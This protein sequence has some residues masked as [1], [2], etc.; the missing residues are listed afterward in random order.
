MYQYLE[1]TSDLFIQSEC[2]R[3]SKC[4]ESLAEGLFR[5]ISDLDGWDE[6]K[7]I[8][9]EEDGIDLE[10]LVINLFTRVLAEMDAEGMVGYKL[11]VL[12]LSDLRVKARLTLVNAPAKLH[13]KA[14]TFHG[15]HADDRSLRVLFDI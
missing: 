15:F 7:I 14:V 10:D 13:V 9:F 2:S 3:F 8:E 11:D 12:D 4:I 5:A 1:H 6:E